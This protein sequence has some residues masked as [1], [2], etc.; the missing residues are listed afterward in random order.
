MS[1]SIRDF[2][3]GCRSHRACGRGRFC[4]QLCTA[5]PEQ[6]TPALCWPQCDLLSESGIE[7]VSEELVDVVMLMEGLI[8]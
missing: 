6:K 5:G 2:C 7:L 8:P 4:A 3:G 1:E